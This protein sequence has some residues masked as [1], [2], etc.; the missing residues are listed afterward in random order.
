MADYSA[1]IEL[2]PKSAAAYAGRGIT[3]QSM[4]LQDKAFADHNKSIELNPNYALAWMNRGNIYSE[5]NQFDQALSDYNKAI[6]LNPNYPVTYYNLAE[7]YAKKNDPS[8]VC[9]WLERY[10][11]FDTVDKEYIK[12]D[13]V[14]DHFRNTACYKKIFSDR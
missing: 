4:G 9:K 11:A 6:A 13:K 1:A 14:F 10:A 2:N 8:E 3:Y 5:R 7:L 12:H